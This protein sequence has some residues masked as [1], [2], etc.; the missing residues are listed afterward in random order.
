MQGEGQGLW[1]WAAWV[2][3]LV[4]PSGVYDLGNVLNFSELLFTHLQTEEH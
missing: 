4:F 2:W 3:I 1:S